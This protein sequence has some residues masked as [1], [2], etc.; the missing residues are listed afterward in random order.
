[1]NKSTGSMSATRAFSEIR[2]HAVSQAGSDVKPGIDSLIVQ[3]EG[4]QPLKHG[5]VVAQKSTVKSRNE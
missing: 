3:I 5:S 2:G 1:W 4:D